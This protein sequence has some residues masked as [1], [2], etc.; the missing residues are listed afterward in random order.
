MG[1]EQ[2][3]GREAVLSGRVGWARGHTLLP[4][5]CSLAGTGKDLVVMW[6]SGGEEP[7]SK[8]Q[9]KLILITDPI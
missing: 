2:L 7:T 4:A 3:G 6:A 9:V 5:P 8:K 1:L